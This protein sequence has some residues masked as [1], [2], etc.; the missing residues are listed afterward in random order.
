MGPSGTL[1]AAARARI[2][3]AIR[4]AERDTAGEIVACV[5][6]ACDE[7]GAAPWRLGAGLALLTGLA[8]AAWVPHAAEVSLLGV[9]AAQAVAAAVGHAIA[10]IGAV[11]RLLVSD[12]LME[13]R[14][15]TRALATFAGA[16]LT[17]TKARTGIL[18]FVALFEHRV[19][20]LGDEGIDRVLAPGE[21]WEEVKDLALREIRAGRL[22]EGLVA[23]IRRCGE[24]LHAHIPPAPHD[25]DELPNRVIVED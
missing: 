21:S 16:G 23:A 14:A 4:D 9:L 22:E 19:I 6:H 24:I 15:A 25:V 11:R 5:V 1:D 2:A 17:R 18:V 13:A 3:D 7:Y 20:V 10:G 8:I 12:A